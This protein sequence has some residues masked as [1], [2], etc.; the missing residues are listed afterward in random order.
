MRRLPGTGVACLALLSLAAT[1]CGAARLKLP[2]GPGEPA[3]DA[4]TVFTASVA[5]CRGVT[6]L[7]AEMAVSGTAA[8]QRLRGR[9]LVGLATPASALLDAAAPFGASLFIY[10]A[11]DGDAT[12]LLPR[13]QRVLVHGDPTAVLEAVAGVPLDPADLR[14]ALTG[15][16]LAGDAQSG[17]A[18]GDDWRTVL[19]NGDEAYLRRREGTWRLVAWVH[20]VEGA[21]GWR[22]DYADFAY[23]LPHTIRLTSDDGGRRF[24]LRLQ[25]SQI[26]INPTLGPEVFALK[27]PPALSPI[28]LEELRRAGPM[29]ESTR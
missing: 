21:R 16:A 17:R 15:C 5:A 14:R 27:I 13:D 29:A 11:H 25:L 8:G 23:D 18:F 1:G 2:T 10:S 28:T 24:D 12:L 26:A 19:I 9:V 4:S 3:P 6:S 22:A 20:R 7:S